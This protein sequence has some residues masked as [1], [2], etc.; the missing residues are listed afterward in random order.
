VSAISVD[1][2]RELAGPGWMYP[3]RVGPQRTAPLLSEHLVAVHETRAQL[4]EG[5][6]SDALAAAGP[7]A[8]AIDLACCEGWFSHK[9]L[10]WGA[11]RVIGVDIREH[12]VRRAEL[13]REHLA[14]DP[15]RLSFRCGDVFALDPADLGQFDVVLVLG[16]I[17]HVEDPAGAL[18][19]AHALT[20]SMCAI[21]TQ[22]TRQARPIIYGYGHPSRF[23]QAE[24]SFAAVLEADAEVNA[25]ASATGVMSLVP[26][27]A[28]L[29]LL[30]RVAGF[31]GL[32]FQRP[33]PHHDVQYL[34]GDRV[35]VVAR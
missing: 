21:E 34:R 27:R 12:N 13:I 11:A 4:L 25:L 3:W 29:E 1:L 32:D 10:E 8:T 14:V 19:R 33:S 35:V 7:D 22:L 17:Y 24:A 30:A 20:G 18:R 6:V 9:L 23:L 5:P 16:L 31:A 28:A 15:E 2:E 26:N